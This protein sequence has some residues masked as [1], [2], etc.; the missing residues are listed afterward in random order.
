M[1]D[2][3]KISIPVPQAVFLEF[4]AQGRVLWTGNPKGMGCQKVQVNNGKSL[5]GSRGLNNFGIRRAWALEYFKICEGKSVSNVHAHVVWYGYFLESPNTCR[6]AAPWSRINHDYMY[7]CSQQFWIILFVHVGW[8]I[9]VQLCPIKSVYSRP[10]PWWWNGNFYPI[11][12][13]MCLLFLRV[14]RLSRIIKADMRILCLYC[15]L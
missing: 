14:L 2:I 15:K 1:G 12:A 8:F 10:C 13:I 7:I 5:E 3:Q 6:L 4:C 9:K 11:V